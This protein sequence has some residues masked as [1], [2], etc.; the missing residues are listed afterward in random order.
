MFFPKLILLY[1]GGGYLA[2]IFSLKV[3]EPM[4]VCEAVDA[5]VDCLIDNFPCV[6][7]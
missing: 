2:L 4:E 5:R 1:L 6:V 3:M 7:I